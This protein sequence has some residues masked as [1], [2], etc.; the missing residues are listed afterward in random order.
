MAIETSY[1]SPPVFPFNLEYWLEIYPPFS[2][3]PS[4]SN[5]TIENIGRDTYKG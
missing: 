3:T 2:F 1:I 4:I 5:Y